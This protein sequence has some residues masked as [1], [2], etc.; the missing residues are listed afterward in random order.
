M[1]DDMAHWL[2]VIIGALVAIAL[3]LS[4]AFFPRSRKP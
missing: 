2:A 3:S 1:G 4:V